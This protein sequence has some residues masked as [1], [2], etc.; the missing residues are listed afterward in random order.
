MQLIK[1]FPQTFEGAG[2][3]KNTFAK[4]KGVSRHFHSEMATTMF[5]TVWFNF[6]YYIISC[7][8]FIQIG[9]YDYILWHDMAMANTLKLKESQIWGKIQVS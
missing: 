6:L 7:L 9:S 5:T 1:G 2:E 4:T 8:S 3:S